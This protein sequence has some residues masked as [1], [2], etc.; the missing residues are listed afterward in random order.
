MMR[1]ALEDFREDGKL[2][3]TDKTKDPFYDP[4]QPVCVGM[5]FLPLANLAQMMPAKLAAK[6]VM[7]R[8]VETESQLECFYSAFKDGEENTQPQDILDRSL[9]IHLGI[10]YALN[11]PLDLCTN[12]FIHYEFAG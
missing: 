2:D 4:P 9:E 3:I 6:I 10:D 8:T 7:S 12:V 1:N 11:L 5:S